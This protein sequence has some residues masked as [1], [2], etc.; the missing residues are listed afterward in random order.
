[1]GSRASRVATNDL[2]TYGLTWVFVLGG[3]WDDPHVYSTL[4]LHSLAVQNSDE[5]INEI[6]SF[7]M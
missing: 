6:P 4:A 3:A 1:M 5:C 2:G 7:H